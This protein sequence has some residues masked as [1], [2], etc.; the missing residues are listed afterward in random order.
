MFFQ[1]SQKQEKQKILFFNLITEHS[2]QIIFSIMEK[3]CP[4]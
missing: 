2:K 3:K 1:T 4:Q